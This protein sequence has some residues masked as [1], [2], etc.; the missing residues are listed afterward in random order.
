MLIPVGV[1]IVLE[2][3][4][5]DLVSITGHLV[6]EQQPGVFEGCLHVH[7]TL[8]LVDQQLGNEVLALRADAAPPLRVLELPLAFLD[9]DKGLPVVDSLKWGMS[10]QEDV[11]DD[12]QTPHV[13]VESHSLIVGDLGGYKLGHA[14]V[15]VGQLAVVDTAG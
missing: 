12:S 11:S 5:A 13:R 8:R 3:V 10:S 9:I 14:E 15:Q 2:P 7:T 6:G 4:R 1:V